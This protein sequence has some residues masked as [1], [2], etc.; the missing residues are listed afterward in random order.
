MSLQQAQAF[1]DR[2]KSDAMFSAAIQGAS[3]V[4]KR[5]EIARNE[6]FSCSLED[7]EFLFALSIEP[8]IQNTN[9]PLS[10]QCKGPCH[11]KCAAV[12]A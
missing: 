11:T 8:K 9:L 3:D 7:I 6:G 4:E 1:I 12:V 5:L 2:M 10:Y